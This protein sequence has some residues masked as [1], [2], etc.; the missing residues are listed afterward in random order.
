MSQNQVWLQEFE[1]LPEEQQAQV[2]DFVHALNQKTKKSA[3]SEPTFKRRF[4]CG[5]GIFSAVSSDFD[6]PL[7]EFQDYMP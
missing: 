7:P 2:I 3:V 5:Q 1:E 4:G 6:D